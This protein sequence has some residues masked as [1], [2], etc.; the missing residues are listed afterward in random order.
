MKHITKNPTAKKSG[1]QYFFIWYLSNHK[2]YF[3]KKRI[4][5]EQRENLKT[6]L[7]ITQAAKVRSF[8]AAKLSSERQEYTNYTTSKV[9]RCTV[10]SCKIFHARNET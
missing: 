3:L 9:Q 10:Q 2:I 4:R 7:R 6:E 5:F 8:K 1:I